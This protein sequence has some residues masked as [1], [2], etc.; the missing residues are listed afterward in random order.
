MFS[1]LPG[2]TYRQR[3]LRRMYK[4]LKVKYKL[5]RR[6]KYKVHE[7]AKLTRRQRA[8]LQDLVNSQMD[9][10]VDDVAAARGLTRKQVL[11]C[12]LLCCAVLCCAVLPSCALVCMGIL[13]VLCPG[14][15]AAAVSLLRVGMIII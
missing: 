7:L 9:Q 1:V 3:F 11:C 2:L 12:A 6:G 8:N 15:V 10:I 14:S 4:K 5:F 13:N